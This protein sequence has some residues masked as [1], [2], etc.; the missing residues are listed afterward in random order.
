MR[1]RAIYTMDTYANN[2]KQLHKPKITKCEHTAL[3]TCDLQNN[4][5][6]CQMFWTHHFLK[7]M[8]TMLH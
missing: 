2:N 4:S 3:H 7:S 8:W 6:R 5:S 1:D